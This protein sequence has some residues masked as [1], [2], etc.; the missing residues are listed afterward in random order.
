FIFAN[1]STLFSSAAGFDSGVDFEQACGSSALHNTI[2]G[3]TPP[4][5]SAIEWR[6]A[7]SSVQVTNHLANAAFNNRGAGAQGTPRG[8]MENATANLFLDVAT[9]DL[10]IRVP[11]PEIKGAGTAI[12]AG[13]CDDDI[14]GEPRTR[15]DIGADQVK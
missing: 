7:N 6:F 4:S 13:L 14:D 9:G 11:F 10:H 12:A 5:S 1:D 2:Y 3:T 15:R 8:N